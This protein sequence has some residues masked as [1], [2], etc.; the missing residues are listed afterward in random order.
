MRLLEGMSIR[1][2]AWEPGCY[3]RFSDIGEKT[4]I[5][6]RANGNRHAWCPAAEDLYNKE[7]QDLREDW[8]VIR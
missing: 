8:E 2:K 4:L 6:Y 7:M 1:R 3:V 5:M